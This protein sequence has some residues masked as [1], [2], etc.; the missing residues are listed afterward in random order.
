MKLWYEVSIIITI[1]WTKIMQIRSYNTNTFDGR[2]TTLEQKRLQEFLNIMGLNLNS[3]QSHLTVLCLK[4]VAV[5][6]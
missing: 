1:I 2:S 5:G 4:K 6:L 3:I